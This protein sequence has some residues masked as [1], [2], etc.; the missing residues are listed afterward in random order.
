MVATLEIFLLSSGELNL[1][2]AEQ[3]DADRRRKNQ[4]LSLSSKAAASARVGR[5]GTEARGKKGGGSARE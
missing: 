4:A 2:V 1:A 5:E 3:S